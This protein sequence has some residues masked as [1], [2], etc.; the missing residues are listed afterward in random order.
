MEAWGQYCAPK[1][2]GNVVQMLSKHRTKTAVRARLR[3][4]CLQSDSRSADV[5]L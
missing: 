2:A 1:R 4:Y 3:P 5:I